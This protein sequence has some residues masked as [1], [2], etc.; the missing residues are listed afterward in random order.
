MVIGT[1]GRAAYVLDDVRPLRA[2]AADPAILDA[3]LHLFEVPSTIQ[4]QV[5]QVGGYRFLADAMFAGANREYGALL[6]YGIGGA[7]EAG[8]T[9]EGAERQS[10]RGERMAK[11]EVLDVAGEVIRTFEGPAT[12]GINRTAWNLRRD[13]VRGPRDPDDEPREVLPPGPDVLPGEY[14]IRVT[15][16]GRR[17]TA[18]VTVAPDPRFDIPRAH[19]ER[20]YAVELQAMRRREVGVDAV[21]RIRDTRQAVDDV[22]E[23]IEHREDALAD[24]ART[25][26]D[27]LK[28]HLTKLEEEFVGP[29]DLQG[30]VRRPDAA[31]SLLGSAANALGSSWEAPTE[32][33]LLYLRQAEERLREALGRVNELFAG[34]V[35]MFRTLVDRL[36]IERI[37][38]YAPLEMN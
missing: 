4:Y 7:G 8:G 32:T 18:T 25:A 37:P 16:E 21:N 6:T 3:P 10:G 1:H 9:A 11:I 27:S 28:Q 22:L 19:R 24:S 13:G 26:A 29:Q 14:T 36:S 35:G 20:K 5:K 33:Q 17:T 34:E 30:I 31:L 15:L 23:R 38:S 12:P 2:I